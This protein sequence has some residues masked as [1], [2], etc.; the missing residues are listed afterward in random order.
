MPLQCDITTQSWS[1]CQTLTVADNS[2][3]HIIAIAVGV[4]LGVLLIVIIIVI[5][6]VLIARS[7]KLQEENNKKPI[8]P[9]DFSD[10]INPGAGGDFHDTMAQQAV[11]S[12][13]MFDY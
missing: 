1:Q 5:V 6:M 8:E 9:T 3:W 13:D 7:K 10:H 11:M 12:V 2:N 4:G